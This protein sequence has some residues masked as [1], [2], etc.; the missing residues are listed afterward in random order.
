MPSPSR[1]AIVSHRTNAGDCPENTLIGIEAAILDGC[2]AVEVDVR[3]TRDGALVLLHDET[4]ARVT[5]DPRRLD[6]VT[7]DELRALRVR[8]PHGLHPPQPIPTLAEALAAVGG[9]CGLEIDLP[10]R[11]LE[12]GIAAT[13]RAAHAEAWTW[14]TAH[15]P[16]DAAI[17]RYACP[18]A[19]VFLS[20]APQPT[21][22]RD[23]EDAIEVA[24]RFGLHGV[25]PSLAALAPSIVAEAHGHGLLV[26]AW[27]VNTPEDIE[28]ALDLGVDGITTDVP[29]RVFEA[30]ARR[31]DG[32]SPGADGA[33]QR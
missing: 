23:I 29:A 22:V 11:G 17:L 15:P 25:N 20:V 12:A 4:L 32:G 28:R 9:R 5:G 19:R 26:G 8:D 6:E 24:A 18:D 14:F 3:A 7:L 16:E 13:V 2:D 27:T 31:H 1:P 10:M 33:A 21:W 30:I